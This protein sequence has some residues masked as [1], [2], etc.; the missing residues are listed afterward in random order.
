STVNGSARQMMGREAELIAD[1]G[2]AL[3][4]TGTANALT[5]TAN[6]GF[7]AYQQGLRIAFKAASTNTG[8]T[9]VN[10]N[11]LGSKAI[12]KQG[13]SADVALVSGD[14]VAGGIFVMH[15]STAANSAAGAW[16]LVNP[17][18][19]T[20]SLV[21]L[22]GTQTLTN[23]TLTGAALN[24]TLGATTPSTV[25]GTS[26]TFSGLVTGRGI[27]TAGEAFRVGNDS[28]LFDLDIANTLG[29][30]GVA[31]ATQGYIRFG[32]SGSF[33]YDGTKFVA[34]NNFSITGTV[35]ATSFSGAFNGTVGATTPST[36]AGTT[37]TFSGAISGTTG[38]FSGN[39]TSSG[40]YIGNTNFASSTGSVTLAPTGAGS[41]FLRPNG[42]GSSTGQMV[43]AS[44][45]N[46][47]I[48]GTLTVTG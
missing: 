44:T 18:I 37:G 30:K 23:K 45:G 47:T 28:G 22:T 42:I 40:G 20:T 3:V 2:G 46:V 7:D 13:P 25:A 15:Y 10:V 1:L 6:S 38:T 16:I 29:I 4:P 11:G 24:G 33:G 8:A 32:G 35:T 12:R 27:S 48:N 19:D 39:V 34:S 36:V 5:I 21:T 43:V 31:D 14:I 9:T 17:T 41:V 26:G